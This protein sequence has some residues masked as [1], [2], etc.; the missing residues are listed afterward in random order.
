M[1][2]EAGIPPGKT[3]A[4]LRAWIQA[5]W[6]SCWGC[7]LP[8]PCTA[9]LFLALTHPAVLSL[10]P[11]GSGRAALQA[12]LQNWEPSALPCYA[13]REGAAGSWRA[14]GRASSSFPGGEKSSPAF[15]SKLQGDHAELSSSARCCL[16]QWVR[17]PYSKPHIWHHRKDGHRFPFLCGPHGPKPLP[18][19]PRPWESFVGSS[20]TFPI[21]CAVLEED[22][23][24]KEPAHPWPDP[25]SPR[26]CSTAWTMAALPLL[27]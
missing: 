17:P 4:G 27:L 7:L 14:Q 16:C 22:L 24:R 12:Q 11:A 18:T 1:P 2:L 10:S 21:L 6:R 20:P 23:T 19:A 3:K 8:W 13:P 15:H 9:T 26:T 25:A 5:A